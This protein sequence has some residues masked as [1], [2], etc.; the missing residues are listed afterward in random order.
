MTYY[1]AYFHS[2]F[3]RVTIPLLEIWLTGIWR[4]PYFGGSLSS[5]LWLFGLVTSIQLIANWRKMFRTGSS[6]LPTSRAECVRD[7]STEKTLP[8]DE[9][10]TFFWGSDWILECVWNKLRSRLWNCFLRAQIWNARRQLRKLRKPDPKKPQIRKAM[11]SYHF[12]Y[13]CRDASLSFRF[14]LHRY[15]SCQIREA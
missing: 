13:A 2:K 15:S 10:L 7:W 1:P 4:P 14:R 11:L 6:Y 3:T 12:W 8:F 9:Q 5:L